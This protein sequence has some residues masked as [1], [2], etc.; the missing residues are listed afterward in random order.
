MS[1][2]SASEHEAPSGEPGGAS[3]SAYCAEHPESESTLT[4]A[5]C[6][7]Y[8]CDRCAPRGATICGRCQER[9]D[10][11]LPWDARG[12]FVTRYVRTIA[13]L[14]T[15]WRG[16]PFGHLAP[17]SVPRSLGFAYLSWLGM[18]LSILAP[19]EA[20]GRMVSEV[21]YF[22]TFYVAFAIP[23]AALYAGVAVLG[24]GVPMHVVARALGGRAPFA[25]TLRAS[26][27]AQGYGVWLSFAMV[28]T[29]PA[30]TAIA[31]LAYGLF[32]IG[33]GGVLAAGGSF[34]RGRHRLSLVRALV[35]AVSA[36]TVMVTIIGLLGAL[37]R[38]R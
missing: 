12:H 7:A 4:C 23:L 13:V 15:P 37:L 16:D 22:A 34:A 33:V 6:G 1:A 19:L 11:P 25:E 31:P 38:F 3:A 10:V 21:P 5:R 8:A 28:A 29:L 26:A 24:L 36:P 32:A 27:Y 20:F 17:G 14:A 18:L 9:L 30:S 35:V 2:D